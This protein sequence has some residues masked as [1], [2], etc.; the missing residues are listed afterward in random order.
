[1]SKRMGVH[2]IDLLNDPDLGEMAK[3]KL[4]GIQ[5]R[6]QNA[7]AVARSTGRAASKTVNKVDAMKKDFE[8]TG[9]L[10]DPLKDPEAFDKLNEQLIKDSEYRTAR[11]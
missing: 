3:A 8:K 7:K 10:P 6:K 4:D 2:P 11:G 5:K 9:K 1:M